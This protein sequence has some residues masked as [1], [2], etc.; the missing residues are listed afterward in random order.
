MT[1]RIP[2]AFWLEREMNGS[3]PSRGLVHLDFLFAALAF[4]LSATERPMMN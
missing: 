1:W 4:A 2:V 3:M